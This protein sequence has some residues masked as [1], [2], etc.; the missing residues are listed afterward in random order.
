MGRKKVDIRPIPEGRKRQVTFMKRKT[1]LLKKAMELSILCQCE[2]AVVIFNH[3]GKLYDYGSTNIHKTIRR[4]KNK[5]KPDYESEVR[6]RSS[7]E[8][9]LQ[10]AWPFHQL[11]AGATASARS[12]Q[13]DEPESTTLQ[14]GVDSDSGS[15]SDEPQTTTRPTPDPLPRASEATR[16]TG[17]TCGP[18]LSTHTRQPLLAA[19]HSVVLLHIAVLCVPC[20]AHKC[21]HGC[22]R[23]SK[24]GLSLTADSFKGRV[25]TAGSGLSRSNMDR[26]K[27]EEEIFNKIRAMQESAAMLS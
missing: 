7:S 24:L 21:M 10:I 6:R 1:G 5:G 25:A 26:H 18:A 9:R 13:E 17:S 14:V 19:L 22:A 11:S 20:S 3:N 12:V 4:F 2:M 27:S 23:R 8:Q 15:D 16:S